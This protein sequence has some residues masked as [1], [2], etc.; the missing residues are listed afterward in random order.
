[1]SVGD[2][3]QLLRRVDSGSLRAEPDPLFRSDI[4]GT[5]M[6][7]PLPVEVMGGFSYLLSGSWRP[8]WPT[9][10]LAV[11]IDGHMLFVPAPAELRAL[12]LAFGRDK[13]V[14]RAAL[15]PS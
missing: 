15:I 6:G 12:L 10:R 5:W 1:M 3:Q 7:P 13:D 9:T 14:E 8:V 11:M 2:A 4:F